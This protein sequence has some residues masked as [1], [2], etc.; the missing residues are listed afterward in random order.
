M[1]TKQ[2]KKTVQKSKTAAVTQAQAAEKRK[3]PSPE[4]AFANGIKK[5]PDIASDGGILYKWDGHIW[6][7]STPS[8]S[9]K[10]AFEWLGN[11]S[12]YFTKANMR[13]AASCIDAAV[14]SAAKLPMFSSTNLVVLPVMNGYLHIDAAGNIELKEAEKKFGLCYTIDCDY[15]PAANSYEFIKFLAEVLPDPDVREWVQSYI[16]Y[17]LMGDTRFQKATFWLGAGANGKST[18]AEIVSALHSKIAAM[19]IDNLNGFKLVP[20]AGASLVYVDETPSRVDEQQLKALIS[21]GL[22]QVDRKYR[23]PMSLRPTA[24]WIICGNSL[25]A[26]SDQSNGFWRRMP[27]VAFERQFSEIEQDP[28]L[29]HRIIENELAGVLIWAIQGL[30]S[31]L[32]AGR[33]PAAPAAMLKAHE[34]GKKETNS[35]LAWFDDDR[36]QFEPSEWTDRADVYGDYR[37]WAKERGYS[38]VNETKFWNRLK[39]AAPEVCYPIQK[40]VLGQARRGAPVVLLNKKANPW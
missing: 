4:L 23:E 7:P 22:V 3:I 36:V 15:D 39:M 26:I 25:P 38:P 35:V 24:K 2:T 18:L 20:L 34:E 9:E 12:D 21:G 1:A 17:T 33:L 31:V 8:E 14:T 29:A 6:A 30:V 19:T 28:L 10:K 13:L 11:H 32:K 5:N 37:D 27:I 16:G 40:K